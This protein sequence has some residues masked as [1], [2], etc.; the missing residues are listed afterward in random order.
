MEHILLVSSVVLW[1]LM[2][3]NILLTL[4]LA[5]RISRQLPRVPKL[6]FLKPGRPAPA[7]TART[8]EGDEI[9]LADYA[10]HPVAFVFVSPH[11][12]ACREKIPVLETMRSRA[13]R[14]GVEIVLVSDS[15]EEETRA[16]V[17]EIETSFPVLVAPREHTSF[18]QITRLPPHPLIAW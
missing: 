7:F 1:I 9:T 17:A 14:K 13:K 5:R 12:Q 2:I 15:G 10:G 4:G 6:E 16:Y 18:W 8:L 11:C 3:F